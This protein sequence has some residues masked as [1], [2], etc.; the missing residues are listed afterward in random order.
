MRLPEMR[1]SEYNVKT[2][3]YIFISDQL[4]HTC[5]TSP[6]CFGRDYSAIMNDVSLMM[7]E[8]SHPKHIGDEKQVCSSWSQMNLYI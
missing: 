6:T 1:S 7:A 4:L 8:Y 2:D 5:F 3:I